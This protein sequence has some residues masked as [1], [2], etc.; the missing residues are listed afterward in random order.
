MNALHRTATHRLR[1][2]ATGLGL[3]LASTTV[4]AQEVTL[5]AAVFVP[6]T[7]TYGIPFKRFVDHVN[8]TGK[9]V[10]QIR[11]VGG[12]EAV[13]ADGQAQAVKT[14]V[15]D[16][17]S[18]PPAYYK[19]VMVE[20]DAQVLSDMTLAE[21]R[22]SGAY[23]ALNK[24]AI[25]RLGSFYLTT[26]GIGVP[27]HLYV[28]KDMPV[29]SIEDLK[30]LRFRGQPNYNAIFKHYG[31]AGVNVAAP[32]TYTALER[33]TV[34]GYGWPLWGIN[35]FGWEK[36]TKVR[37][38]PGFYNVIV[39][40]LMNKSKYDA[41]TPAQRKVIDDAVVWFEKDNEQYTTDT[42]KATLDMQAK[43]G[44][45]SVD[46]GPEFKKMAVDLYWE[47]LKKLSPDAIAKLQPILTKK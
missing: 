35:D 40:I 8:E 33:G 39:N 2:V 15:L 24:I 7:T 19:S 5:K 30:G 1:I 23:D 17:A 29:K 18:I 21:Q 47:D 4:H 3:L 41:L 45:K 28:T 12:P 44:I 38:D 20:G 26:Y 46:F 25:E 27:F 43:A 36:L 14:G 32:E 31:I 10:L 9:G 22:K 42:T 37:V 11:I 34:Q 6:P 13:P 16:I